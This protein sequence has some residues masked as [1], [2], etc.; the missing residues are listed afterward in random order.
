MDNKS[1]R[2]TSNQQIK[3][4]TTRANTNTAMKKQADR[5]DFQQ[6]KKESMLRSYKNFVDNHLKDPTRQAKVKKDSLYRMALELEK[7]NSK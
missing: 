5:D 7:N 4:N 6:K 3:R 1:R 2:N